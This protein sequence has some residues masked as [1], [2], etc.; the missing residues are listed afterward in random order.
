M[1][2]HAAR[3][4]LVLAVLLANGLAAQEPLE[5]RG[6]VVSVHDGDTVTVKTDGET[7]RVR[8]A[9]IDA[10]ELDQP[11]G[12]TARRFTDELVYRQLVTLRVIGHDGYGRTLA[13][14]ILSDGRVLER[15]LLAA[16]LAW[17]YRMFSADR[18]LQDLEAEARV[19]HWGLW[20]NPF[21]IAPWEWRRSR[22]GANGSHALRFEML[23][24][25]ASINAASYTRSATTTGD[26]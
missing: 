24:I 18:D 2:L 16:G 21:P 19:A 25:G 4:I 7:L 6:L 12:E 22:D 15:E 10:P 8:M 23:E 13:F 1:K 17:Q 11:F 14:V 9:A 20:A 5:I 26:P 3:F